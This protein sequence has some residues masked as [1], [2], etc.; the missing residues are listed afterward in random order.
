MKYL[1]YYKCAGCGINWETTSNFT[2]YSDHC[3]DCGSLTE[4]YSTLD[5]TPPDKKPLKQLVKELVNKVENEA[6]RLDEDISPVVEELVVAFRETCE[7]TVC[8]CSHL[9]ETLLR[10]MGYEV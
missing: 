2:D 3:P 5:T 9:A 10:T 1:N 7:G 4:S 8:E 6:V